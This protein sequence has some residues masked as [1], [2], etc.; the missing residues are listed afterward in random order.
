MIAGFAV[1]AEIPSNE[2]ELSA[3][4]VGGPLT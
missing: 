1:H 4:M 2:N 3:P